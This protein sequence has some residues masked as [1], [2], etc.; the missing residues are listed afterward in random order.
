[1]DVTEK[2]FSVTNYKMNT[3]AS[4]LI[5]RTVGPRKTRAFG[6]PQ[7]A[8]LLQVDWWYRPFISVGNQLDIPLNRSA[9]F[10]GR[11]ILRHLNRTH[12]RIV[13]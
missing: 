5:G 10:L 1:M 13:G 2:R 12:D 8:S 6:I 9:C 4:G 7:I 11:F 3:L